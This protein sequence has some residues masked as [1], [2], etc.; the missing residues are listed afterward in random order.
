METKLST[1]QITLLRLGM[2]FPEYLLKFSAPAVFIALIVGVFVAFSA[3][4]GLNLATQLILVAFLI[5]QPYQ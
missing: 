3:G 1:W 2:P 5:A 4:T